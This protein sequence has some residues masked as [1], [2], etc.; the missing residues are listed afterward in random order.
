MKAGG[1]IRV[2]TSALQS[3]S[4]Y[5]S[6]VIAEE[7]TSD[8]LLGLLLST[9]SSIEPIEQFSLYEVSTGRRWY[10]LPRSSKVMATLVASPQV[11]PGQEYQR[12]LHPDDLPLR[13]LQQRTQKGE[14]C[15]FLVRRNPNYPRRR[16]I[17]PPINET[18]NISASSC[19]S[20]AS[21]VVE[22][23]G[24]GSEEAAAAARVK[25]QK[26][27]EDREQRKEED[28]SAW[29]ERRRRLDFDRSVVCNKCRNTFKSCEFCQQQR[30]KADGQQQQQGHDRSGESRKLIMNSTRLE[31]A[32]TYNPV[33]N[34]REI[35]TV[36]HSFS[37]LGIDKKLLDIQISQQKQKKKTAEGEGA[38][39][40]RSVGDKR[41][42]HSNHS[43]RSSFGLFASLSAAAQGG[44][45]SNCGSFTKTSTR[46]AAQGSVGAV[47]AAAEGLLPPEQVNANGK[48]LYI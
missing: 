6:L 20:I 3:A 21:T 47:A 37:S 12:K 22:T 46:G 23:G 11:S 40:R 34:I 5:K 31:T 7:T 10:T 14:T 2:H 42:M 43:K 19:A 8:E 32:T 48:F 18:G 25:P 41:D 15:H 35:R 36:C 16:Q 13:A 1:L 45:Q 9:Y 33:Y 4:Q 30:P 39:R 38:L 29:N 28:C 17:L 44:R 27:E 26:E 24:G